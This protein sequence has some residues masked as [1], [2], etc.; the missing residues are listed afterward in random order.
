M[1]DAPV[2][3]ILFELRSNLVTVILSLR[4]SESA[5]EPF[6]PISL[7]FSN[8]IVKFSF[9]RLNNSARAIEPETKEMKSC[10]NQY[11]PKFASAG[12]L[13]FQVEY[14]N[15][16]NLTLTHHPEPGI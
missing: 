8:I 13:G 14:S 5:A 4:A 3:R 6:G 12:N 2:S 9:G 16:T 11:R 10:R 15:V 7:Q 1:D